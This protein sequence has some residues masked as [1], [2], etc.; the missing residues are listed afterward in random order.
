M[1]QTLPF[2]LFKGLAECSN[3]LIQFLSMAAEE[4]LYLLEVFQAVVCR[5]RTQLN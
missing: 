1:A 3:E 2:L 5:D 4:V